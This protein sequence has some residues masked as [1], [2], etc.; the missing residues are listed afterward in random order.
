M[1]RAQK[2]FYSGNSPQPGHLF[3]I[4]VMSKTL[5]GCNLYTTGVA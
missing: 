3:A 1:R 2:Y 5:G 4:S